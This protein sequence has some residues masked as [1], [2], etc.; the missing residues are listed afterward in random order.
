MAAIMRF[1]LAHITSSARDWPKFQKENLFA[2]NTQ[3]DT[4]QKQAAVCRL[5][6]A[7]I[8]HTAATLA[9]TSLATKILAHTSIATARYADCAP[10][11]NCLIA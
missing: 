4:I 6:A 10:V 1:V 8:T 5:I 2:P 9:A 7:A 11:V 3:A